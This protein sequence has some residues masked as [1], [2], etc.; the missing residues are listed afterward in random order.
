MISSRNNSLKNKNCLLYGYGSYGMNI[1]PKFDTS[2]I[3]L[4]DRGFIYCVAHIRGS[5]INGYKSWLDGKMMNKKNTFKDFIDAAN[6]LISKKYT[7]SEKLTIWGRSAGGLL[8]GNVI[9]TN[10]QLANMAI[11]GVPFVDVIGTMTDSCQPLVTEEYEEWGNPENSSVYDYME[12]YDPMSN[13][14]LKLDYPNLFIYSN[15]N[16]TNVTYHQVLKYFERIKNSAVFSAQ[17]KFALLK[18]NLK[19]GH[20]QASKK[21]E[22][23]KERAE[24]FSLIIKQQK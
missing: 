12:S 4:L 13:I 7:S 9:N 15:I 22:R 5:S 6:W 2:I 24:I 21:S 11:L 23:R 10:P 14:N 3:S 17:D 8:I 19:Y 18:I 1:E 20:A 16:D